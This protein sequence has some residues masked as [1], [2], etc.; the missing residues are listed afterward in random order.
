MRRVSSRTGEKQG[1]DVIKNG[2][3]SRGRMSG[4]QITATKK[5]L[6]RG[7][8]QQVIHMP[9]GDN[10]FVFFVAIFAGGARSG[11]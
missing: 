2:A 6:A 10:F 5:A 9:F 1:R 4:R 11:F 7:T 8:W 3:L